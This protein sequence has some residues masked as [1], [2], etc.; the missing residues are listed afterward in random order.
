MCICGFEIFKINLL[1]YCHETVMQARVNIRVILGM[2]RSEMT[3]N[4]SRRNYNNLFMYSLSIFIMN[5]LIKSMC[6]QSGMV[7]RNK[8]PKYRIEASADVSMHNE[9]VGEQLS[10]KLH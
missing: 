10:N 1:E 4:R 7:K 8:A 5:I 6:W 9:S 2:N 3:V